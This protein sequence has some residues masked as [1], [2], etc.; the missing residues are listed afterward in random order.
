MTRFPAQRAWLVACIHLLLKSACNAE[1]E[2]RASVLKEAAIP[3]EWRGSSHS[4]PLESGGSRA[5]AKRALEDGAPGLDI[6]GVGDVLTNSCSDID[7]RIFDNAKRCGI[8]LSMPC[9]DY[10]RC[11]LDEDGGPKIY[12]YDYDCSLD[13]SDK[14]EI[15]SKVE[16]NRNPS[17]VFRYVAREMGVLADTYGS[18]CLFI[19]V[20]NRVDENPCASSASL[21]NHGANH[22][23][24]DYTDTS[25]CVLF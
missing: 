11:H 9:F 15:S 12:V 20:N 24:I 4:R 8:P 6:G 5:R 14:L 21:W 25:R 7:M 13:P 16:N 2:D 18:A 10:S 3:G 19:H 17:P 23:M 1:S 22:L